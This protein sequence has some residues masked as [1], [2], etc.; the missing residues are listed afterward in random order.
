ML[1]YSWFMQDPKASS[2]TRYYHSLQLLHIYGPCIL[3]FSGCYRKP[4]YQRAMEMA[5]AFSRPTSHLL[6]S[7]KGGT[8][9]KSLT[10]P[11]KT[12]GSENRSNGSRRPEK[13]RKCTSQR[14]ATAC[15][16]RTCLCSPISSYN[17]VFRADNGPPRRSYSYPRSKSVSSSVQMEREPAAPDSPRRSTV[18]LLGDNGGSSRTSRMVLTRGKSLRDNMLTRRFTVEQDEE[19]NATMLIKSTRRDQ[20]EGNSGRIGL[21]RMRKQKLGPSPL[22]RMVNAQQ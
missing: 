3:L 20:M 19:A 1:H 21:A 13:L 2:Q 16:T 5:R 7:S 12:R 11:S 9:W 6:P 15:F 14:A 10:K 8:I 4:W 22:S 17:G 18:E